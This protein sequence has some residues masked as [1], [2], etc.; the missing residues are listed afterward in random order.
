MARVNAQDASF[1]GFD[2]AGKRYK[3]SATPQPQRLGLDG[4][5][6]EQ[7]QDALDELE[8]GC[9][10]RLAFTLQQRRLFAQKL[11]GKTEPR[12]PHDVVFVKT[13]AKDKHVGAI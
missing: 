4:H 13:A 8:E 6:R 2:T 12:R 3:D 1:F 7:F 9:R 11:R 10:E 5:G